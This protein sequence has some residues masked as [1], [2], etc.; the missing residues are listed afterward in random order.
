MRVMHIGGDFLVRLHF[1]WW[2]RWAGGFR[3]WMVGS[4]EHRLGRILAIMG[5][6]LLS[7]DRRRASMSI[8]YSRNILIGGIEASISIAIRGVVLK[9]PVIRCR[10]VFCRRLRL[11]SIWPFRDC[12]N[13]GR[14]YSV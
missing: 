3:S 14:P 1:L 7:R 11:L 2:V 13:R 4:L 12:Q 10:H 8:L 5:C 6:S 9:A